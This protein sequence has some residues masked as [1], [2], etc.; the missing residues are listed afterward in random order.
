MC[1]KARWVHLYIKGVIY[2]SYDGAEIRRSPGEVGSL[3]LLF[4]GFCTGG[5]DLF[6]LTV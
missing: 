6:H 4:P 5:A 2:D 1:L 3:S